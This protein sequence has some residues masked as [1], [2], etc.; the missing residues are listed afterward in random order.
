MGRP[1][2]IVSAECPYIGERGS[3]EITTVKTEFYLELSEMRE[4]AS[5][6]GGQEEVS[7]KQLE[8]VLR[9]CGGLAWQEVEKKEEVR[10]GL[11]WYPGDWPC[12]EC[13]FIN[14]G[15]RKT[16]SYC[17]RKNK[18]TERPP[19]KFKGE[20]GSELQEGKVGRNQVPMD[21]LRSESGTSHG[22]E[23]T[24]GQDEEFEVESQ[25]VQHGGSESS[26]AR[27]TY[28]GTPPSHEGRQLS[29]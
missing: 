7:N 1:G 9:E 10:P 19:R 27:N 5:K 14:Y 20:K 29:K 8:I 25:G 3:E 4:K 18:M 11:T 26:N 28:Y 13:T 23:K 22:W 24:H 6:G 15:T 2:E 21:E 16:C 12:L 17:E